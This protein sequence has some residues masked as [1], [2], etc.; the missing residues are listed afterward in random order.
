[1]YRLQAKN[2][3]ITYPQCDLEKEFVLEHFQN[4]FNYEFQYAIGRESHKDGGHHLHV[5]LSLSQK[6]STRDPRWA[7]IADF[8][9]NIQS[10]RSIKNVYNYV[11]KDGD[12]ISTIVSNTTGWVAALRA[13]TREDFLNIV[14]ETSARDYV[15]QYD[16]ITAFADKHFKQS[17]STPTYSLNDFLYVPNIMTDWAR[18]N[19]FSPK[20]LGERRKTLILVGPSRLGKTCWAR[21]LT[22]NHIYWNGMTSFK[23]WIDYIR[24]VILDDINWQNLPMK[25]QLLG[26]QD[27]F[28]ATDKYSPKRTCYFGGT[29]ILLSNSLEPD[30]ESDWYSKNCIVHV[31]NASLF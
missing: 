6:Y 30:W 25:T 7:D 14:K 24:L 11:T 13:N 27:E 3:F 29:C 20:N 15:L 16:R 9:P 1:M 8:H 28:T 18:D 31:I 10:V 21:S 12:Y 5:L 23:N 26:C 2:I 4:L 17:V 19:L 22:P